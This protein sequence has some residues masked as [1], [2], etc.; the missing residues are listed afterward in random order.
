MRKILILGSNGMAGHVVTMFLRNTGSYIIG[1]ISRS[2]SDLPNS[3][4]VDVTDI[5]ALNSAIDTFT[6]DVIVNCLGILNNEA[7]TN[8]NVSVN[9][10]CQIAI[11]IIAQIKP[12]P[13][14]ILLELSG[15]PDVKIPLINLFIILQF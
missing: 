5:N 3:Y 1:Q 12:I 13:P 15:V 9:W 4:N 8:N 14:K 7:E 6:P 10:R 11:N 2:K